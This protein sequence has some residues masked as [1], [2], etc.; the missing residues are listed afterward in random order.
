MSYT[1][2]KKKK[3]IFSLVILL[4]MVSITA[5]VLTTDL[6]AKAQAPVITTQPV[7]GTV[8]INDVI[9]LTVAAEV[10]PG[11]M[12]SYQWFSNTADSNIGGTLISGADRASF[13]PPTG[14]EGTIFY[15]VV[16]TNTMDN[17]T[18][19]ITSATARVTVSARTNAQAPRII[20]HPKSGAVTINDRKTL[21]VTAEVTD[22]GTLS[23]QWFSN[24]RDNTTGG[25]QISGAVRDTF[26]PPTNTIGTMYYYVVVTN[27]N[28]NAN[29]VATAATVSA[30]AG[31]TVND[32][33]NAAT[34]DIIT[35]PVGGSVVLD[36]VIRLSVESNEADGGHLSYQWYEND[37]KSNTG[38]N[39]INEA[40]GYSFTPPTD[41]AG[42][43]FYYVYV[44]NTNDEVTGEKTARTASEA[45]SVIVFTTPGEPRE[46]IALPT[47]DEVLLSWLAP[48]DDGGSEI[49]GYEVSSDGGISWTD[50][51]RE[52]KHLFTGLEAGM[53]YVFKVRAVNEAGYGLDAELLVYTLDR[54]SVTGVSLT[55]ESIT[56]SIGD[57]ERITAIVTPDDAED[58]SMI[59]ES[60][61][62]EVVSVD[63]HG[64]VTALTMGS[65]IITVT[66]NDGGFSASCYVTVESNNTSTDSTILILIIIAVVVL[67][68]G[69][70]GVYLWRR[71]R[72]Q[73]SEAV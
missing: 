29:G 9:T 28:N 46:L 68:G 18:V 72:A 64:V 39:P 33:V 37:I 14:T 24:D 52:N 22:G 66:T 63:A 27:T 40:I 45:V 31:V 58:I 17:E 59:W 35:Q 25:T 16:V 62:T 8:L 49:T 5:E 54:V 65:A 71:R 61:D 57:T 30:T 56:L 4:L 13:T 43:Y 44:T 50:I 41:T 67:S 21:S 32:L 38:G 42:E 12:L 48:E 11:G 55:R 10:E 60:S 69:V 6:T 36:G 53:E 73:A 23:Y 26:D 2:W 3:R 51:I 47:E 1:A 34:P 70:I 20:A 19:S 15:Y 7:G